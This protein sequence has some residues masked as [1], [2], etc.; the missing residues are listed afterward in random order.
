MSDKKFLIGF[1]NYLILIAI[2]LSINFTFFTLYLS[3]IYFYPVEVALMVSISNAL[4][5]FPILSLSFGL[6]IAVIP[7]KNYRYKEKYYPAVLLCY[8]I[9]SLLI[10]ISSLI[11][12]IVWIVNDWKP[13]VPT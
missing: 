13:V 1:K 2:L 3:I 11:G 7:Y 8:F 4:I 10:T 12:T 5:T 9:L 6:V